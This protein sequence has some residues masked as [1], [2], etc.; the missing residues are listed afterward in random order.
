MTERLHFI[1]LEVGDIRQAGDMYFSSSGFWPISKCQIGHK[2]TMFSTNYVRP[3]KAE[4]PK[5]ELIPTE[6]KL[7]I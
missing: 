4:K 1:K 5:S 2:I 7:D 6:R 3:V